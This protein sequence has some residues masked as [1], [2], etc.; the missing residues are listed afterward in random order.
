M[1]AYIPPNYAPQRA[2]YK[3][4][5]NTNLVPLIKYAANSPKKADR[6]AANTVLNRLAAQLAHT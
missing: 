1:Q 4:Q 5:L 6:S 2:D 3:S